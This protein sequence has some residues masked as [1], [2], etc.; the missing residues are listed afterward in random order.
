MHGT[1]LL[2]GVRQE[3]DRS[4]VSTRISPGG[5]IFLRDSRRYPVLQSGAGAPR[6]FK[7]PSLRLH[8]GP[9]ETKILLGLYAAGVK[10]LDRWIMWSSWAESAKSSV[11]QALEKTGD[12]LSKAATNAG[13]SART[14]GDA[15]AAEESPP[16]GSVSGLRD[17]EPAPGTIAAP[18]PEQQLLHN[19]S[20]GWSS[21]VETTRASMKQAE[22]KVKEQQIFLQERLNKARV[23]YYKRDPS[24]PLD[25]AALK[26][27]EVVYITDR[28]ITMGHPASKNPSKFWI[29]M[30]ET[31][32]L[33]FFVSVPCH[34]VASQ[35]DGDI[36]GER[37]LAAVGHLLNRRHDG[38]YMVWNLSEVDYDVEILDDQV[39]TFSF[40]GSP[41]PPLG[42]L[43]KLLVSMESWLKADDRNVAVVHCLTGKGRTSTVL[44]AFLCWMGQA[45]F[46]DIYEALEY[47]AVC[48]QCSVDE[49]TIPSQQRY[50]SYFKNMLDGI[51]PSQPPLMLKRIIMSEAPRFAKGPP[52]SPQKGD[53]NDRKNKPDDDETQ[54]LGCVPYL[55]IFKAG[56]LLHTVPASLH[57]QQG[58]SE[59]PFC[60]L[61]DGNIS[62]HVNL[63]IQG[64]ILVR[65]RHLTPNKKRVSMFR[66][67]FHT[68]YAPQNVMRLTKAQLDGASTDDRFVPDFFLDFIFEPADAEEASKLVQ[69][70]EEEP[71]P[72]DA[73]NRPDEKSDEKKRVD[74][75]RATADDTMLHRDSRFWEVIAA[76]MKENAADAETEE[77]TMWGPT[78]GRRRDFSLKD[79]DATEAKNKAEP[80]VAAPETFSIGGEFDF[81]P[82][83]VEPEPPQPP[84]SPEPTGKLAP[85]KDS[86]LEALMGAL[87]ENDHDDQEVVEFVSNEAQVTLDE[88]PEVKDESSAHA[89]AAVVDGEEALEETTDCSIVSG[90]ET[91]SK[92]SSLPCSDV[93]GDDVDVQ[94]L[95]L[96]DANLNLDD[97]MNAMLAGAAGDGLSD[98]DLL[99]LDMDD[100]ELD[101]LESFLSPRNSVGT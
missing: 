28:L 15:A 51:R 60:Q 101:D 49:L 23:S 56:K 87:D 78:V 66:A 24:L 97:D 9:P 83:L 34:A 90:E 44:A 94:A 76:R 25:V 74:A 1:I 5:N 36:T 21:V 53:E 61:A 47:I 2:E 92:T 67:A 29:V 93:G 89:A 33:H 31:F 81:L 95:L 41:S 57:F 80:P 55:Q 10:F 52:R 99:N 40:P 58:D 14:K 6:P 39:L 72:L 19:L 98:D 3:S 43:L 85:M 37:K 82:E 11:T 71:A 91:A 69:D 75:V 73:A 59:L 8:W 84:M 46:S 13:K 7:N 88:L 65:A 30:R 96:A 79:G 32:D 38:R 70:D 18:R 86:L 77:D 12:A 50:A 16:D 63:V 64:D 35:V 4:R 42:L 62:F 68:G 54:L 45:Q 20:Q 100:A 17:V 26:D 27:A 48:K 22:A